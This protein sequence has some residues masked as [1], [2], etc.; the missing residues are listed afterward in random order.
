MKHYSKQVIENVMAALLYSF[1]KLSFCGSTISLEFGHK[2]L[3][4]AYEVITGFNRARIL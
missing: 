4:F 3:V 1:S 2:F